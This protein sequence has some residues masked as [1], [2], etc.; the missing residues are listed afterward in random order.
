M[1]IIY[2]VE[3]RDTYAPHD[4][5]SHGRKDSKIFGETLEFRGTIEQ[6]VDQI[7]GNIIYDQRNA[8]LSLANTH[9]GEVGFSYH[10]E[11]FRVAT[12]DTESL[13]GED[14]TTNVTEPEPPLVS[15]EFNPTSYESIFAS[16]TPQKTGNLTLTGYD[17]FL[18]NESTGNI[19]IELSYPVDQE[20]ALFQNLD[21]N[22]QYSLSVRA[23]NVKGSS[24]YTNEKF[25][26]KGNNGTTPTP[27]PEPDFIIEP[28]GL[29]RMFRIGAVEYTEIKALPESVNDF[30][31][32]NI[33]RLLTP[34]ERA[35]P[36]PRIVEPEPTPEPT[37]EPLTFCVNVYTLNEV[38]SV[39]SEHFDS[40]S[41]ESFQ[42]LTNVQKKYVFLCEDGIIPTENQVRQFYGFTAEPPTNTEINTTMISQSIGSFSLKDG[43]LTGEILY[44]A[45]QAFNPTY[46]DTS[47]SS[48]IQIK[49]KSG[50]PIVVKENILNFT[51]N[52]RDERIQIDEGVGNFKELII[53]FYVWKSISDLRSF[54]DNKEIQVVDETDP[55]TVSCP[56]GFHKD[57]SGKCVPDDPVG[58]V[59]KDKLIDTLKGFLFGTVALSLLARKY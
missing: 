51:E 50:I 34:E 40:I 38:G 19:I 37:P 9:M 39:L 26:S 55:D 7:G 5:I 21:P 52:Q 15:I 13:V 57:F 29:V 4:R 16:W 25:T 36:Y 35:I 11:P 54:S 31:E 8:P 45:N 30:I 59:P 22:T 20:G 1:S 6:W 58:D 14:G 33:A 3:Y 56:V 24:P 12:I 46:Y 2:A 17:V 53:E 47:I 27:Q 28:D 43:R 41:L 49:N 23:K 48:I 10:Y 32:R 44:I 42:N 18:K